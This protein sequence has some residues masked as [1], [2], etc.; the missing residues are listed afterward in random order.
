ME[1]SYRTH[2]ID[3]AKMVAV[4]AGTFLMGRTEG[5][6][7]ARD[8]EKPQRTV[9]LSGFLIDVYPVT[10][11]RF[12][13]FIA[14]GGYENSQL[15]SPEGWEWCN[16]NDLT[17]PGG[18]NKPD[19]DGANQPVSGISWFEAAAYAKWAGKRLP[20]E[21]QWERAARGV[22]GREYPWGDEFPN[23]DLANYDNTI[24]CVTPVGIYEAGV[25][26]TGCY[27]MAGNVNN[28]CRDWY[29]PEFYEYA[30]K[31]GLD[32]DPVLDDRLKNQLGLETT[33]KCDR[34]GGFATAAEHQEIL[35]CT[36]KVAWEP[37]TRELWNGFRTVA[38]LR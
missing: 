2:P 17:A 34:G 23:S 4:P 31:T 38:K 37:S 29:W 18:W 27:D 7:F 33:L 15:W 16:D 10:N 25:S 8:H 3:G 35:N 26:T 11:A 36:D 32:N 13:R 19:W 30:A 24:G 6:I 21:A 1:S 5:D 12:K 20:T 9:F 14:D 22:D 28:W